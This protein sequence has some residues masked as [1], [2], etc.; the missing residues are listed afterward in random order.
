MF[1]F[2]PST[3]VFRGHSSFSPSFFFYSGANPLRRHREPAPYISS[4][5]SENKSK[6]FFFVLFFSSLSLTVNGHSLVAILVS[7]SVLNFSP[8]AMAAY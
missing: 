2:S 8:N 3:H 1:L 7:P 6:C 4:N 5:Y